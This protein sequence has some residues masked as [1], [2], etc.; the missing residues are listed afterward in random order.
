[1]SDLCGVLGSPSGYM[2][3]DQLEA[4]LKGCEVVV[5][6]AGVPRKPGGFNTLMVCFQCEFTAS[7]F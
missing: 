4:A 5:I 1:M 3:P 6:P 2:G 7:S